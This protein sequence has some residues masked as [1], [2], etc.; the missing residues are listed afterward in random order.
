VHSE[1]VAIRITCG[2]GPVGATASA[3]RSWT[4]GFRDHLLAS[5]VTAVCDQRQMSTALVQRQ[6]RQGLQALAMRERAM[7]EAFPA[8]RT[9]VQ[10]GLFDRR[11]LRTA[12]SRRAAATLLKDESDRRLKALDREAHLKTEVRLIALRWDRS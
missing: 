12:A 6:V 9:L 2:E 8:A 11:A 1:I 4:F 10:A 3:I 5:L 7:I